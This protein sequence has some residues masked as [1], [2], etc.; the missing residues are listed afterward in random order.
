MNNASSCNEIETYNKVVNLVLEIEKI[1]TD[2]NK[3]I[4]FHN[5]YTRCY[6]IC[7]YHLGHHLFNKLNIL[8][9]KLIDNYNQS[10]L[11]IND[12]KSFMIFTLDMYIFFKEKSKKVYELLMFMEKARDIYKFSEHSIL[13][14]SMKKIFNLLGESNNKTKLIK[15]FINELNTVRN[16]N[17]SD[18]E[19]IQKLIIILND[20][21]EMKLENFDDIIIVI[22]KETEIFFKNDDLSRNKEIM[23]ET[24]IEIFVKEYI[25]RVSFILN[26]EENIF[27]VLIEKDD[28]III[29]LD[30]LLIKQIDFL[31]FTGLKLLINNYDYTLPLIFELYSK[32]EYSK[33]KLFS[34][35]QEVVSNYLKELEDQFVTINNTKI[36][37]F[38]FYQYIEEINELKKKLYNTLIVAS[39]NNSNIERIIKLNFEKLINKYENFIERFVKIIH[40]E[41]KISIKN[42]NNSKVLEFKEKFLC[43]YKF[44]NDKDLF[45]LEYRKYLSKRLLRNSSMIKETELEFFNIL[46]RESGY[47]YVKKIELMIKDIHISQDLTREY[48]ESYLQKNSNDNFNFIVKIINLE[49]WP[50]ENINFINNKFKNSKDIVK[51][52]T[53]NIPSIMDKYITQFTNFYYSKFRNRQ[54]IWIHEYSWAEIKFRMKNKE[55]TLIVSSFQMTIL[56]YFN[57]KKLHSIKDIC[58][59]LGINPNDNERYLILVNYL[60][61]LLKSDLLILEN[62]KKYDNISLTDFISLNQNF[63][64]NDNKINLNYKLEKIN[65][66]IKETEI[67]HF[68]MEDRKMLIDAATYR[69]LKNKKEMNYDDMKIEI[70]KAVENYFI[71]KDELICTR[72]DN[73]VGR[74]LIIRDQIDPNKYFYAF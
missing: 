61:P 32:N 48:K 40:E 2:R 56:F 12:D 60:I 72:L 45:E 55:Y 49:D 13:E 39:N 6:E 62:N 38:N 8:F 63:C 52:Q 64:Y 69:I 54:I 30:C 23:N 24:Q 57:K 74:G 4:N 25:N 15:G 44:I 16:N 70:I 43:I 22:K 20:N 71:P 33:T 51:L 50:V 28:L 34:S 31:I 59:F 14:I 26:N 9:D 47:N 68:I 36:E 11:S 18:L 29:I 53:I 67:S 19:N 27:N 1:Y 35:I 41:I 42:K 73:L 21:M 10:L 5:I 46:Q 65:E 58:S 66:E 3:I 17:Y 7:Q 37:Y